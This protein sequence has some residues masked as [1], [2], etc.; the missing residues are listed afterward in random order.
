MP[1]ARHAPGAR[2]D[3][4]TRP[5]RRLRVLVLDEALP[6]PPDSGKRLR[7][8]NLLRR[9][10]QRHDIT[11]LCYGEIDAAR[12]ADAQ[13]ALAAAGVATHVVAPLPER[14]GAALYAA[15]LANCFSPWPYSV[16]K[17]HTRRFAAAAADLINRNAFDLVQVEWTPYAASLPARRLAPPHLIASHN[18]EAQ[19][20]RRRADLAR[21]AGR[22]FFRWQAAKMRRFERHAFRAARLVTVVSPEDRRAA[23]EL[24]AAT[25][26]IVPNG[27]DLDYFRPQPGAE[28]NRVVFVGA[29]DWFPNQD[30]VTY[31]AETV[32]PILRA[33]RPEVKLTVVGRRL[34]EAWR[35][36]AWEGVELV[37]E[38]ADVRPE[39]ARA[40]VAVVPLRIGGGSRLKILE[41]LAMD[42]PIVS[43][44]IG[45][46]GL[47]LHPGVHL[48][49][50]D[51]PHVFAQ[52]VLDLLAAPRSAASLGRAGGDFVRRYYG[53]D[54]CAQSLEAAW[55][56]AAEVCA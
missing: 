5:A 20:W 19:I 52:R 13:Q 16:A 45:A 7:T 43:T 51:A 31:F 10:A 32:L 46:E 35:R 8:W 48:H 56:Q 14:R 17:H 41:A 55:R 11:L 1:T 12:Q 6:W 26:L 9:L 49:I 40:A 22:A 34:P 18:I 54:V 24:Q 28:A 36:R 25:P 27:V 3:A 44:T 30:A 50:A 39:F 33:R 15:L 37:G 4:I 38:V 2:G 47:N 42:K 23:M 53:W 29:L 21:T